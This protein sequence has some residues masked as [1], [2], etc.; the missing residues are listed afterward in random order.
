MFTDKL[1]TVAGEHTETKP[2]AAPNLQLNT[3]SG[4]KK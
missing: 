2:T 3:S 1:S 4:E